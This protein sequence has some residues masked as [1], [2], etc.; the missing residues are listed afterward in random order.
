[1]TE[2]LRFVDFFGDRLRV[3]CGEPITD[4]FTALGDKVIADND[5][6]LEPV[7]VTTGMALASMKLCEEH[8]PLRY[9]EFLLALCGDVHDEIDRVKD[10]MKLPTVR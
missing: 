9:Y 4:E 6:A 1:M 8:D 2:N 3:E 10:N 5:G 7:A